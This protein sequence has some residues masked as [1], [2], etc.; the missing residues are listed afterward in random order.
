MSVP[1]HEIDEDSG[2]DWCDVHECDRPC[3]QC[4]AGTIDRYYDE[5]MER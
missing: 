4:F 3:S 1:D 2:P 5:R